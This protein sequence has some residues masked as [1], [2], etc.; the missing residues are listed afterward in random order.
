MDVNKKILPKDIDREEKEPISYQNRKKVS[1]AVKNGTFERVAESGSFSKKECKITKVCQE[2]HLEMTLVR[3]EEIT[4]IIRTWFT[5]RGGVWARSREKVR[6]ILFWTILWL[7]KFE[8][9]KK[10]GKK[11]KLEIHST[12][13]TTAFYGPEIQIRSPDPDI[14]KM[15]SG[16]PCHPRNQTRKE[17]GDKEGD[18]N[19]LRTNRRTSLRDDESGEWWELSHSH[20]QMYRCCIVTW[21]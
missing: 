8:D 9:R 13:T 17:F 15:M 3:E 4:E 10:P 14:A 11:Y 21:I 12:A 1:K 20:V 5:P 19:F 2:G 16:V 7:Q 18:E 6:I